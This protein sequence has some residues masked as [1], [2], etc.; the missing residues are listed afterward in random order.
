MSRSRWN[1]GGCLGSGVGIARGWDRGQI[2]GWCR[3]EGGE[4]RPRSRAEPRGPAGRG[5]KR[6][7]GESAG[8]TEGP[9][10]ADGKRSG[11]R[12]ERS[13]R[14]QWE[15]AGR[16]PGTAEKKAGRTKGPGA[17]DGKA[18]NMLG[19]GLGGRGGCQSPRGQEGGRMAGVRGP[20]L[21]PP[22]QM[23]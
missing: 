6:R 16:G 3:R 12:L 23:T 2:D 4:P 21:F 14:S 18:V 8:R 9:G 19:V 1:P 17:A 7:C 10:A 11:G 5:T 22:K 13:R 15:T 20:A